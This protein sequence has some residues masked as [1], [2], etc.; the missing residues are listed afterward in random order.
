MLSS[1]LS[2]YIK[3]V[4]IIHKI[5]SKLINTVIPLCSQLLSHRKHGF[6]QNRPTITNICKVKHA[7]LDSCENQPQT[8]P[9]YIVMERAFDRINY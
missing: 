3:T 2:S 6:R 5:F 7:I 9:I 4:I 8:D 1:Y